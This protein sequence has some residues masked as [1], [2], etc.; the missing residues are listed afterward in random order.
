MPIHPLLEVHFLHEVQCHYN[1]ALHGLV[2]CFSLV[3]VNAFQNFVNCDVD[4]HSQSTE[5]HRLCIASIF[6]CPTELALEFGVSLAHEAKLIW[7]FAKF[8]V[9][10]S[11][12]KQT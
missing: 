9:M 6:V 12:Q 3:F 2:N 1:Y 5:K 10:R 7:V 4:V 8:I 11:H